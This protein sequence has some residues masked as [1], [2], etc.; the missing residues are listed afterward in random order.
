LVADDEFG[1]RKA[2]KRGLAAEGMDVAL[3]ADGPSTLRAALTGAFDIVLLDIMLPGLSGY[4]ILERMRAEGVHT[5]VLLI[6]AKDGEYD[7]ADG[8]DLGA[9]GYLVKPF[10]Y[11][12]LVAQVNQL[13]RRVAGEVPK[14]VVRVGELEVDRARRQVRWSGSV[15][16]LSPREYAVLDVLAGRAGAVVTKDDLL[17]TVWGDEQAAT[18]NAVEVYVGYLRRKLEAAGAGELLQ[19][20][21]GHGYLISTVELAQ[22]LEFGDPGEPR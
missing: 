10:S 15:L 13:L 4:R 7:Q 9:D 22:A 11:R 16:E 5:P 3:T 17:R 18:R 14:Q 6:S 12:V 20:V 21:R 2:L 1:V 19:T 8:F